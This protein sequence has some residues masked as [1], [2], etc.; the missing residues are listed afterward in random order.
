MEI[1]TLIIVIL[2]FIIGWL[3]YVG[4]LIYERHRN[5]RSVTI[6]YPEPQNPE[7]RPIGART[8]QTSWNDPN[9]GYRIVTKEMPQKKRKRK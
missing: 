2:G 9:V 8:S 7:L 1:D 6:S 3:I 4:W 5:K